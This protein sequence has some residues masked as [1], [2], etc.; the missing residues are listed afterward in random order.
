MTTVEDFIEEKVPPELHAVVAMVR[1][2]MQA[3]APDATEA[4]KYG[5]P[6]WSGRSPLAWIS[7]AKGRITFSFTQGAYFDDPYGLLKGNAKHARHVKLRSV[8]D[9]NLDAL[10]SYVRQAVERD[11]AEAS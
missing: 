4:V 11:A 7:P 5:L 10:R 1:E 9:A 2:L 6:M 3:E 8:E